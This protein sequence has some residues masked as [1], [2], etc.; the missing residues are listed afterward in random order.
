MDKP[1]ALKEEEISELMGSERHTTKEKILTT[2]IKE[3]GVKLKYLCAVSKLELIIEIF[4]FVII[5]TQV[6]HIF[7]ISI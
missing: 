4:H 7:E 6:S 1:G 5:I 3:P 2:L